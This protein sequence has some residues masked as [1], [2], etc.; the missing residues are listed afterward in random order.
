MADLTEEQVMEF[1]EAF[2]LFDK[3]GDGTITTKVWNFFKIELKICS[4]F[5]SLYLFYKYSQPRDMQTTS[6]FQK[7]II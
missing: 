3:D 5:I 2:S 6:N 4:I 1:K 7:K